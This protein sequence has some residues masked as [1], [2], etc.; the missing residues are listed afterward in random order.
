VL[1]REMATLVNENKL[2][3]DY[4]AN[5]DASRLSS[6]IYLQ[7]SSGRFRAD[8]KNDAREVRVYFGLASKAGRL[9]RFCLFYFRLQI[10]HIFC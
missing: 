4:T 7:T 5:F 10:S 1:G 8:E 9:R 2:V 6:G 3:G